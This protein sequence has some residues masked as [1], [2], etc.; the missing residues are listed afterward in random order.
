MEGKVSVLYGNR[1]RKEGG[2]QEMFY[3]RAGE[4]TR[5]LDVEN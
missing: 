1:V 4:K 2:P 5:G 3:C